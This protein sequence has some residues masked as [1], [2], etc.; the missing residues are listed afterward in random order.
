MPWSWVN[1]EYKYTPSTVS[2]DYSIHRLQHPPTTASTEK[3][4]PSIHSHNYK[5]TPDCSFSFWGASI[6]DGLPSASAPWELKGKVIL[7][8]SHGCESTNR[9]IVSQL[10]AHYSLTASKYSS[11]LAQSQPP[12][13][14]L[15]SLNYRLQVH[16]QTSSFT[17]S[18]YIFSLIR[19]WP[20]TS[21]DHGVQVHL[22]T[23]QSTASKF[24][25]SSPASAYLR[26]RTIMAAECISQ[27]ARL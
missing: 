6:H 7:S 2:T 8:H 13:V 16:L 10:P 3:Y 15:N 22:Q 5:L 1:A 23:R 20:L 12:S 9:C 17:A 14:Y 21:H 26:T 25:Q 4:S 19:L 27:L 24:A 11:N 18:K